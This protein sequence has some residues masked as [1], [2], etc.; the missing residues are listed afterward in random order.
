MIFSLIDGITNIQYWQV[1][2]NQSSLVILPSIGSVSLTD[3]MTFPEF[4]LANE[5]YFGWWHLCC[6][7]ELLVKS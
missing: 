5:D 3:I 7:Y 6:S 4:N 1:L 2:V